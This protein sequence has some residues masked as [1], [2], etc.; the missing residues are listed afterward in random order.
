[1]GKQHM[2]STQHS[3]PRGNAE[4]NP[5]EMGPHAFLKTKKTT[6]TSKRHILAGMECCQ[7]KQSAFP[8]EPRC[9][10]TTQP[11]THSES[12]SPPSSR[13]EAAAT[14]WERPRQLPSRSERLFS[15]FSHDDV[16]DP[17][18]ACKFSICRSNGLVV[19]ETL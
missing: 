16:W 7:R 2:K 3:L 4:W 12:P 13:Q 10:A 8:L 6:L 14:A 5:T 18:V 17:R 1:M 19:D 9:P 11:A 15:S